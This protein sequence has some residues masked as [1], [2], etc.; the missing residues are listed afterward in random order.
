MVN[1]KPLPERPECQQCGKEEQLSRCKGC[2]V[3]HY[4]GLDHQA[5]HWSEHKS[6]CSSIKKRRNVVE[7]EVERLNSLPG[8]STFQS[9][10]FENSV[11]HFYGI[12]ETQKYMRDRYA[13]AETLGK[14]NTRTAVRAMLDHLLDMLRLNLTD[15]MGLRSWAPAL[16]LRLGKDRECYDFMKWW[17]DADPIGDYEWS[18]TSQPHMDLKGADAFDYEDA[19]DWCEAIGAFSMQVMLTLLKVRMLYC[20]HT[21]KYATK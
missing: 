21:M 16:Y 20:L 12:M 3:V 19:R 17:V 2:M 18:D 5:S 8:N 10:P 7:K 4:C 9:R 13:L 6:T 14:A 1:S 11:G 15:N